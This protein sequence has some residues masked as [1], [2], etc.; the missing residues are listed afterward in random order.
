MA[1]VPG[2]CAS[3]LLRGRSRAIEDGLRVLRLIGRLYELE[4]GWDE[5]KVGA[6]RAALRQTHLAGPLARLLRLTRALQARVLPTSDLDQACAYLLGHWQPLIAHLDH[7][8]TRLDTNSVENAIRPSKLGAKNWLSIGHPGDRTVVIYSLVVSRQRHGHNPHD[9][10]RDMLGRLPA[11]TTADDL[12]ALLPFQ[13]RLPSRL[14]RNSRIYGK[15]FGD[16]ALFVAPQGAPR[17]TL[18]K[19]WRRQ[20]WIWGD[21]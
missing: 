21:G 11:M 10:L 8:Q 13:W 4:A 9:Y 7:V 17:S 20:H 15:S 5:T 16:V 1:R 14:H 3:T 6:E 2:A 19:G 12:H 18:T